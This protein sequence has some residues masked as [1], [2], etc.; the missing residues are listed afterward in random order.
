MFNLR[1]TTKREILLF[2]ATIEDLQKERARLVAEAKH[3]RERAEAIL[4]ILLAKTTGIVVEKPGA[5]E[6]ANRQQEA[7]LDLFGAD[8]TSHDEQAELLEKIQS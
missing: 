4:N 8:E 1:L 3:E 5:E 7:M 2:T 6:M